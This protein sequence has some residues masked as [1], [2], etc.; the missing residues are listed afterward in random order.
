[1]HLSRD[2][3][4]LDIGSEECTYESQQELALLLV[5]VFVSMLPDGQPGGHVQSWLAGGQM[6]CCLVAGQVVRWRAA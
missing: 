5:L 4:L 2:L 3:Q 1:M 6:A